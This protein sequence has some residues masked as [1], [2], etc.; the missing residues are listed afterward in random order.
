MDAGDAALKEKTGTELSGGPHAALTPSGAGALDR[1]EPDLDFIRELTRQAGDTF[2]KCFQCGT[3]SATCALSPDPAPFPRKEMAWANWGLKDQLLSDP[4]VWLCYQCNDC[5]TRCPRGARPGELMAAV[6]RASATHYSFP[7]FLG[8]WVNRPLYLPFLLGVPILLLTLA[9]YFREP[10]GR[11]LSLS[12]SVSDEIVYSYS[13][14]FPHWLLNTVFL[15]FSG[16]VLLVFVIGIVRLWRGM[17]RSAAHPVAVSPTKGLIPSILSALKNIIT[18]AD[19]SLCTSARPR[20][21]SHMS[22]F[23][24]FAALSVVTTWVITSGFNPIIHDAFVYP[25]SFWS[26]WKI[27][28]NLGGLAV[29]GGCALMIRDR[30]RNNDQVGI[31]GFADWNLLLMLLAVVGSGFLTE[32]LHYVRLEPHRHIVYFIH[33][34]LVLALLMYLPYSKLAHIIYRTVAM[35]YAESSGRTRIAADTQRSDAGKE[36]EHA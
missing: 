5:S 36:T 23:F 3:C 21:L 25:F 12:G 2:T 10:V 34:V 19:F 14:M 31:G 20:L 17:N 29:L 26:P 27:L 28:A 11:A 35:V 32:I 15:F 7:T 16:L 33:L 1:I 4:D 30:L 9:L 22:V 13:Y 18:H 6:R 24:G 8:R